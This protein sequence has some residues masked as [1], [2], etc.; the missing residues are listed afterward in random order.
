MGR[1]LRLFGRGAR[2]AGPGSGLV[3]GFVLVAAGLTLAATWLHDRLLGARDPDVVLLEAYRFARGDLDLTAAQEVAWRLSVRDGGGLMDQTD[4]L[5]SPPLPPALC[6][7]LEGEGEENDPRASINSLIRRAD[8]AAL[9]G[10]RPGLAEALDA[11]AGIGRSGAE[12]SELLRYASARGLAAGGD[13]GRA[14]RALQTSTLAGVDGGDVPIV[15]GSTAGRLHAGGQVSRERA[16]LAFHLRYLAGLVAQQRGRPGDAVAH[17]RRALNAVS[18]LI[19]P[20]DVSV[21]GGHYQRTLMEPEGLSCGGRPE[22]LTSLDAYTGLVA[23][24]MSATDFRDPTRLA[25]EVGRRGF[26]VDPDDPLAPLLVHAQDVASGSSQS[27]IPENVF[28]AS[29]NLQR[30]YH[31]NRLR[32]DR[33]LA[34]SRAVLTLRV[35]GDPEWRRA[36]GVAPEEECDMLSG[37]GRSLYQ[38]TAVPGAGG[39][40]FAGG[41][42]DSAWAAVAVHTFARLESECPDHSSLDLEES[43]R[44]DW[45]RLGGG[46]L[47]AGLVA[48]YEA[49]RTVLARRGGAAPDLAVSEVMARVEGDR[50]YF[51]AGRVPPD[52]SVALAPDLALEFVEDW[53]TSVFR[54]VAYH[55]IAQVAQGGTRSAN[56]RAGDASAYV[57]T[58]N[59][60]VQLGGLRPVHAYRPEVLSALARSGG[61]AGR[62]WYRASYQARSAPGVATAAL[63]GVTAI[64][65]L[66]LLALFVN[67]WRYR[68]LVGTDFFRRESDARGVNSAGVGPVGRPG[69][70]PPLADEV[71]PQGT[72][73]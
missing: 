30:V 47:H 31:Y 55:L 24:Y 59:E 6:L 20:E 60:A 11:L 17:F 16:V 69:G 37:L 22:S 38:D 19:R 4:A 2:W 36:L 34:L 65:L 29:S 53:R 9:T 56:V 28:W 44:A 70:L 3:V 5:L 73:S 45:L 15:A 68:L 27:P 42:A 35:L 58:V 26:E 71:P 48:R 12:S 23:A 57:Q 33:R 41:R 66:V 25:R 7:P 54:D 43:V 32:P 1:L 52:M 40:S 61:P 72:G 51:A 63:S 14:A 62:L 64:V 46:L 18:Y 21:S 10:D 13:L 49:L 39:A 8:R 67:V 50:S